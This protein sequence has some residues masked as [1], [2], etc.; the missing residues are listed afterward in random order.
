MIQTPHPQDNSY[1]KIEVDSR[2]YSS[3]SKV[4]K[5]VGLVSSE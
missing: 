3:K 4:P 5:L 1:S 2:H